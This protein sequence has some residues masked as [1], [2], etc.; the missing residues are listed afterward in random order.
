MKKGNRKVT[1]SSCGESIDPDLATSTDKGYL[2]D[3]CYCQSTEEDDDEEEEDEE[4]EFNDDSDL[5][6]GEDYDELDFN[7]DDSDDED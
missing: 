2:C 3:E 4:L 6:D 1:C 7:D 5:E